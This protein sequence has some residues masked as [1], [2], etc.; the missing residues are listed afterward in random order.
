[1]TTGADDDIE[2][3]L[4]YLAL[5]QHKLKTPLAV[6]AGWSDALQKWELL[7]PEERSGGL[8]AIR[9]ATDELRA[10]MDDLIEEARAH[11]LSGSLAMETIELGAF[12]DDL[13]DGFR[14]DPG[15]HRLELAVDPDVHVSADREA[16]RRILVHLVTNAA[17]YSPDGGP[18]EIAART[19]D[20]RVVLLVSDQGMG[21]SGDVEGLFEPFRRGGGAAGIAR[22]TGLGLHVA[23]SLARAMGGDVVARPGD[24][25]GAVFEV[26]LLPA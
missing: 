23:R 19:G 10:Q 25:V 8:A 17:T 26:V 2:A 24:G 22:G 3:R 12:I 9:R 6:V 7:E 15:R 14:L 16:L 5:A 11:L 20:E 18:I 1:M 13:A 4:R 21:L